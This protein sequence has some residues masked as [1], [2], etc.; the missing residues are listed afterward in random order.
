MVHFTLKVWH[1]VFA[2]SHEL[3]VAVMIEATRVSIPFLLLLIA[4]ACIVFALQEL[5][6]VG[7]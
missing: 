5:G 1:R 6:R 4:A 3:A 2:H 7:E